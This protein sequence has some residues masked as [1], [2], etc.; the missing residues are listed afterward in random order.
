M[1]FSQFILDSHE[2]YRQEVRLRNSW[3]VRL[4]WWYLTV[5][6]GVAIV[7]SYTTSIE[8]VQYRQFVV[9]LI[10]GGLLIN[11]LLWLVLLAK[12]LKTSSYHEVAVVQIL[13][14]TALAAAVV[15]FQGGIDSRATALFSIPILAAGVLFIPLFA[16]LSAVLS[17]LLYTLAL[18]AYQYFNP[19]AYERLD[20]LLP[21]VF[22]SFV[23]LLLA[24]IVSGY[25]ERNKAKERENSYAE[26]LSLLRHQLHHP[27]GV[28]AAIIEMMEHGEGYSKMNATNREYLRQLKYENHRIHT[29]ITNL[30]QT[31]EL[32]QDKDNL[33]KRWGDVHIMNLL[34]ESSTSVATGYKR[35]NDL[36]LQI[37]NE[38]IV[39]HGDAE[40]LRLAFENIVENAF[41]FS[42]SGHKVTIRLLAKKVPT[43]EIDIED[44]GSGISEKQQKTLFTAFNQIDTSSK[45]SREA[46]NNYSMGLGLYISK[47]IIEQHGGHLSLQSKPG[48]G[49][50]VIIQLKRDMWRYYYGKK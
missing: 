16:Y 34:T 1:S 44:A 8:T 19:T 36:D 45:E 35:I 27:I 42:E 14:D 50:K 2:Q 46:I 7:T 41:K 33:H 47:L 15:Y 11:F 21:A 37:P 32:K 40:Q 9:S 30:L 17:I 38:D 28:I 23:F 3:I 31:A 49:T 12:N 13:L 39:M 22:Y 24:I 48:Q 29:M 25:T 4:R 43:V 26:L 5:L 10:V 6:G 20:V 18:L